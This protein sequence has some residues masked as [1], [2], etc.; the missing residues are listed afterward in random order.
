VRGIALKIFVSFWLIFAVL[1]ASFAL[2]PDRGAGVRFVDH[3]RQHGAIA[4]RLLEQQGSR[5][6]AE[7]NAAVAESSGVHFALFNAQGNAVCHAAGT[8]LTIFQ[9][10]V[11]RGAAASPNTGAVAVVTVEAPSGATFTAVGTALPRFD[12][13]AIR[14]PFPYQAVAFAIVISGLVCFSMARYLA[15]PLRLVRDTSYRLAA[16]DLRARAGPAIGR[17]RDEIGDLVRDFDAMATRIE[18]LVHA[19]NQLLTDISHE[20]RSPLARLNV[21]LELARRRAGSDAASDLDH[22]ETEAERM[23]EL[24]GRVLALARAENTPHPAISPVELCA[25]VRKVTEDADY[26]AQRQDKTVVFRGIGAPTMHGDPQLIAS[27]VDNIVRNGLRYTPPHSTVEVTLD[28]TAN[29]AVISVR[30]HGPGVPA[31]ELEKIFLPF[32]RVALGRNRD[33]GGVGLGLAIAQRAVAVHNGTIA[34]ENASDGGLRVIIRF[35]L[36]QSAAASPSD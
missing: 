23:N 1:I 33:T 14:P 27:A 6:C 9:P 4:S 32:H 18:V 35:P 30:D 19:Q 5:T 15:R 20:L 26:E 7:Y 8:D 16:G 25:V 36:D 17:R 11:A 28:A 13:N 21:A 12:A 3:L 2:L 10:Y 34:A 29:E 24:I 31:S 22:I